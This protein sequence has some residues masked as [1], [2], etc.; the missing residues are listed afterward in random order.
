VPSSGQNCLARSLVIYRFLSKTS[1]E[2]QLVIAFQKG[3]APVLGH[4]W[5]TV[6]AIPI[7]D[8]PQALDEFEPLVVFSRAGGCRQP[9]RATTS[10]RDVVPR[11]I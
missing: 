11:R 9:T 7:H 2:P 10:P 1:V 3:A 6:N 5:V 4:A 8:S